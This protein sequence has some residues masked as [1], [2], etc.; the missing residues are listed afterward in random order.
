MSI[1]SAKYQNIEK[2]NIMMSTTKQKSFKNINDSIFRLSLRDSSK[3]D[4]KVWN[5][6]TILAMGWLWSCKNR[7]GSSQ[8]R[9]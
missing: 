5:I 3:L 8:S 7:K 6:L 9:F 4:T 1:K 2:A